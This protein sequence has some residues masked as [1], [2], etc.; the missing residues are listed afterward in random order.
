MTSSELRGSL[1]LPCDCRW[2]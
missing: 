1:W 2:S